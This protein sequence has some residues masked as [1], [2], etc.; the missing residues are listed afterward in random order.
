M[1]IKIIMFWMLGISMVSICLAQSDPKS[2]GPS[3][4]SASSV[5][6]NDRNNGGSGD[7]GY[8]RNNGSNGVKVV[9]GNNNPNGVNV[10]NQIINS[11]NDKKKLF[12]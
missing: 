6:I 12:R 11:T 9:T 10:N 8:D 2:S 5:G 3:I 7:Y 4:G 1:R